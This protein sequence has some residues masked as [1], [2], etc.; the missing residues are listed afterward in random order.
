[1]ALKQSVNKMQAANANAW[2]GCHDEA[3]EHEACNVFISWQAITAA[4][5]TNVNLRSITAWQCCV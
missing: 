5:R 3:A 2:F 4:R 1:M